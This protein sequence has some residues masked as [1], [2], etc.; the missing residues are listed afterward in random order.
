MERIQERLQYEKSEILTDDAA[1]FLE[2]L[3]ER[4]EEKENHCCNSVMNYKRNLTKAR[5]QHF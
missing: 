3:H 4:F 5:N 2:K 1:A